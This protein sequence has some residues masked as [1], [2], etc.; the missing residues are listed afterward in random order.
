MSPGDPAPGNH[1]R[2]PRWMA[3]LTPAAVIVGAVIIAAAIFIADR[4]SASAPGNLDDAVTGQPTAVANGPA[5]PST[6][7]ATLGSYAEQIGIDRERFDQCLADTGRAE[8]INEHLAIGN[9]RGVTGTPTFFIND[10]MIVGAQPTSV[11]IEVIER[12]LAG[13]P[14][15][16][17]EY[18]ADIQSLAATEPPRFAITGDAVDVSGAEIHGSAGAAVMIAEFSDFQCPFCQRWVQQSME[19]IRDLLGEDVAFAFMHFPITQIHPNAPYAS[20]AAI[21]AGEQDSFWEMHDLLFA[22]QQEW[23]QLPQN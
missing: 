21:C 18:S 15:S 13:P 7:R 6:L 12:E 8:Q 1:Q 11:F 16:L 3:F 23:A 22:R 14:Q 17:D 10:K 2:D 20:F 9:Q 5:T 4:D 19:P